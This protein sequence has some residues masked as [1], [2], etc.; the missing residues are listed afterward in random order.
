MTQPTP[1]DLDG[2]PD[3][4]PRVPPCRKNSDPKALPRRSPQRWEGEQE[5]ELAP[6]W[7]SPGRGRRCW[8]PRMP[9]QGG[10]GIRTGAVGSKCHREGVVCTCVYVCACA[11][12]RALASRG[13]EAEQP[14]RQPSGRLR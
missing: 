10:T 7:R 2:P 1:C 8:E 5:A 11:R 9:V 6:T 12:A 13:L 3:S 4:S 14:A